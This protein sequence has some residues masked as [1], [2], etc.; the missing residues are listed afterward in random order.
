MM[1]RKK[2]GPATMTSRAT[3]KGMGGGVSS[4]VISCL[5][6]WLL[7]HTWQEEGWRNDLHY[8]WVCLFLCLVLYLVLFCLCLYLCL[9]LCLWQCQGQQDC[10]LE[11]PCDPST[12]RGQRLG[13]RRSLEDEGSAGGTYR[14]NPSVLYPRG[15]IFMYECWKKGICVPARSA[16]TRSGVRYRYRNMREVG[17]CSG[18]R[19]EG[20][21]GGRIRRRDRDTW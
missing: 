9:Y 17:E 1:E 4:R 16:T 14:C 13:Q 6:L 15:M 8:L 12:G 10:S 19:V 5:F 21:G 20:R 11:Y 3:A 2:A 7:G 18:D